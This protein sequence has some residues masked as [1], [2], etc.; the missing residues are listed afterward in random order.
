MRETIVLRDKDHDDD[1]SSDIKYEDTPTTMRMRKVVDDYN[2]MMQRHH[3][4]VASLRKP[5]FVRESVDA[6]G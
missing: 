5:I 4:D 2:E 1:K 3:V 6:E